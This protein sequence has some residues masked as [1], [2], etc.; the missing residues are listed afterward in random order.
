MRLPAFEISNQRSIK[1]AQCERVP[2]LMVI[3]GPNGAGKSTLLNAIRSQAGFT[4]IMYVGPHRAMR[5]QQVQQRHLLAPSISFETLL[6]GQ[7]VPGF[8][9]I[10]ILDGFRDPWGSDDLASYLKHALCQ[11]EVDRQQAITSK[12]DRDGGIVAGTL[13][14]PWKPLRELTQNL[15]PHMS[16]VKIDATNRDQVKVLWR[17]HRLEALVDL[18][19]LSSGEKSIVQMFYPLVEREIKALVKEIDAGPQT[20]ERPEL[21]VLIDEPE[22][23]LHPNLQ[24][25]V[26]DY[27]RVLTTGSHTQVIVATHSPTMVEY[28]SFE[29][30]FLLRPVELVEPE[31]NQLVQ[32]ASNEERLSFLKE[33]FGSTANL[34]ALQPVILVEGVGEKSASKVLPD[35][36]LYRALHPGFDRVTLIPGGGKAE[37]KTLLRVLNDAL[38]QFSSQL[39]AVALL[40]RDTDVGFGNALI[41]LLPVSMIENFLLD[42][43][44]MW[45]A[46]QSVLEKTTFRTVDDVG[47]ALDMIISGLTEAEIGRRTALGLGSSHF[48]PPSMASEIVLSAET[49]VNEVVERYSHNAIAAA[50][51]VAE[52]KVEE[53]RATNRRREDFHGK[54]VLNEFYRT[55]LHQ[56]GLPKVVFTFEAARHARRRRAVVSFFDAFFDRLS[57]SSMPAMSAPAISKS[58]VAP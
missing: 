10:R 27:L 16:F 12:V 25:K 7:N 20:V 29:E 34:T 58:E 19:D 9:G 17:V 23:H 42:P 43:D 21:C 18:D 44:S 53:L 11:I 55:H 5:R 24:L 13:I 47:N 36:K 56:A 35:R 45:E 52:H 1:R 30:L 51:S 4:N 32:V 28:A 41:E 48:F 3:A 54:T 33:V 14:D 2:P 38:Q 22:L 37:C 31:Q 50:A 26:L 57:H 49:Y 8:E 40:D 15:L 46:L 39:Q 6:S